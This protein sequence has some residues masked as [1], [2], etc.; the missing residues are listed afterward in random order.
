MSEGPYLIL[1]AGVNGAGKSTLFHSGMW[2]HGP[3]DASLP[4]VN[5]DEILASHGWDWRDE[6]AQLKAGREAL[7]RLRAHLANRE[8]FNRETTLAG[9]SAI[10]DIRRA[11]E[12][13]YF[14][15]LFYVGVEDPEIANRRI[16]HR[17]SIGGH[18]I[19]PEVVRRRY[20]SSLD[21]LLAALDLCD[22]TYLYDNTALLTLV[23]RFER[24]ELAY[25]NTG[26][27]AITWHKS[28]IRRFG[29][30]EVPFP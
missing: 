4:R 1:F 10:R 17:T 11:C 28:I 20:R 5:P 30:V 8:S 27:P 7:V 25:V 13:G 24:E 26:N 9:R 29:Y 21:N 6:E 14:I 12:A 15:V 22:E 23:A 3:I 19:D 18:S 2:Q 16:A